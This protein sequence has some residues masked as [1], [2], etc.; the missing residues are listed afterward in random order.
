MPTKFSVFFISSLLSLTF[1]NAQGAIP[2]DF[3]CSDCILVI[4][5]PEKKSTV[6]AFEKNVKKYFNKY[7]SGKYEI[8]TAKELET[9][10]RFQ[11]KKIYKFS[12]KYNVNDNIDVKPGTSDQFINHNVRLCVYDRE[13]EKPYP[14]FAAG[15]S[16]A[17][18]VM[19]VAKM[20][21]A[22]YK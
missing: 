18:S 6:P 2:P 12:L 19:R 9:E 4:L 7:Y 1:V 8:A 3:K 13:S 11:D 5:K 16:S 20:L 14:C 15:R 22:T 21:G 10:S 17:E